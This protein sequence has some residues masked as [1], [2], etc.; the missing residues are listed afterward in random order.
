MSILAN[1]GSLVVRRGPFP[2]Q[3]LNASRDGGGGRRT[4]A[5]ASPVRPEPLRPEPVR[6]NPVR[7]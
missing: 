1:S 7:L 3:R 5:A 2:F 6:S 4:P